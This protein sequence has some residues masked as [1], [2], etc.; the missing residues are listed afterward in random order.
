MEALAS[1]H[2]GLKLTEVS[3]TVGLAPSTAHRLLTT[4]QQSRFVRFD[5]LVA[6]WQVG[7]TAFSVGNAFARHRDV[8]TMSRP[9]MRQLMEL[10]GE[11][12]NL[13]IMND[14]E[15]ICMMQ[16][17]C[18]QMMRAIARPGG[19]VK[20]HNSG[21]GKAMLAWL[22]G[23]D[24]ARVLEHQGLKAATEKTLTTPRALHEDLKRIRRRGFA[25]DDEEHAVG[26]RCVAAP[27]FDEHSSP[28]AALSISGPAARVS[29]QKLGEFG[30]MVVEA[31]RAVTAELS[32]CGPGPRKP[33]PT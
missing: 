21:V 23:H 22:P 33:T 1:T 25:I 26:L 3:Q 17:E 29:D 24:L 32:G 2:D 15:A 10:S 5:P 13:Y 18:R 16:I 30:A 27:I 31:A 28:L 9:F 11:T 20:M 4:L 6:L 19:R 7:V 12:A 8:V 14:D